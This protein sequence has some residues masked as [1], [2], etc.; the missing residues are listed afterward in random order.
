MPLIVAYLVAQFVLYLV[1]YFGMSKALVL[2][3]GLDPVKAAFHRSWLGG[4][5]TLGVLVVYMSCRLAKVEP[6]SSRMIGA[7]S[8][9]LLRLPVWILATIWVYRVTRWRKGKLAI[10]V[11]LGLALNLGGDLMIERL[12]GPGAPAF[13]QWV[14]RLC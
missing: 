2:G 11:A 7:A 9:W 12:L 8:V 5:A 4:G 13:G 14:F 1:F 3:S 10:L 6:E